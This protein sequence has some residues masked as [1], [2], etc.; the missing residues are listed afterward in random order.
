MDDNDGG[1]YSGPMSRNWD[2]G[3]GDYNSAADAYGGRY[4]GF[5]PGYDSSTGNYRGGGGGNAGGLDNFNYDQAR[6]AEAARVDRLSALNPEEAE[7]LGLDTGT[8]LNK[9]FLQSLFEPG[10]I[11]YRLGIRAPGTSAE[12]MFNTESASERADRVRLLSSAVDD[13]FGSLA[14]LAIPAPVSLALGLYNG[15]QDYE[16]NQDPR[17]ALAAALGGQRGVLGAVGNAAKGNYGSAVTTALNFKGVNP[18]ESSLAGIGVDAAQG[19]KVNQS[20]GGLFG[21]AVGNRI[22]GPLAGFIGS[23]AGRG[24]AGMF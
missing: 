6:A 2:G 19:R 9:N 11:A 13:T 21:G 10:S 18:L 23:R 14:R 7:L 4:A 15:Y 16:K 3:G 20:L 5:D 17:S 24:L 8:K 12:D 22:G 1:G